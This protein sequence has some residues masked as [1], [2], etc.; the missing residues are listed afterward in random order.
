[1]TIDYIRDR[2]L[3][4]LFIARATIY[5]T[6]MPEMIVVMGIVVVELKSMFAE[7]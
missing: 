3:S 6:Y 2:D 5:E 7:K 1:M 4:T